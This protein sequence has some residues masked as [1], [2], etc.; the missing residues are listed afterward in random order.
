MSFGG[1]FRFRDY[2][3]PQG[4]NHFENALL[5]DDFMLWSGKRFEVLIDFVKIKNEPKLK[6]ERVFKQ[7]SCILKVKVDYFHKWKVHD[8][9]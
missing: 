5:M 1:N 3:S 7:L 9:I 8:M 6:T 4:V 2:Y